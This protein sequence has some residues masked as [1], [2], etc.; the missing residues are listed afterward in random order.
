MVERHEEAIRDQK[1]VEKNRR[2][3]PTSQGA[4]SHIVRRRGMTTCRDVIFG[5]NEGFKIENALINLNTAELFS[6]NHFPVSISVL[7]MF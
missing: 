2:Y 1:D 7:Y 4:T 6:S 5:W 3:S